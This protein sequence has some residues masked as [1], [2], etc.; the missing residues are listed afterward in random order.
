[1]L[2]G[3]RKAVRDGDGA[4][5][6]GLLRFAALAFAALLVTSAVWLWI[7]PLY[8]RAVSGTAEVLLTVLE[9]PRET[10]VAIEADGVVFERIDARSGTSRPFVA[11]DFYVYFGVVPFVALLF[12]TPKIPWRRRAALLGAGLGLLILLHA[13]YLVGAVRL[14][15][16]IYGL[17]PVEPSTKGFY[18][19]AQIALRVLW[20]ASGILVWVAVAVRR[21]PWK[22]LEE[23]RPHTR[24]SR[25]AG[26]QAH[27]QG[28][29]R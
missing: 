16:V 26:R 10:A 20:E 23:D 12:A 27:E 28:C 29:G 2:A 15:Y 5:R 3:R 24:T 11:F 1:M 6:T 25:A 4:G 21:W 13:A 19:W 7:A 8:N 14:L 9:H 17:E 22:H 18:D